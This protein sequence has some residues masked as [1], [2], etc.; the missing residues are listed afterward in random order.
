MTEKTRVVEVMDE[1]AA[2]RDNDGL[3][4]RR[5]IWEFRLKLDGKWKAFSTGTTNY[6]DARKF[7]QRKEKELSDARMPPEKAKWPL[8]KAADVWLASRAHDTAL[9]SQRRYRELVRAL[10]RHFPGRTLGDITAADIQGYQIRRLKKIAPRSLNLELRV[11]RMILKDAKLWSRLA[12]DY[13]PVREP[14]QGIGRVLTPEQE[15]MLFRVA[16][17]RPEW[18]VAYLCAILAA[19]TTCRGGEIKGLRLS[20]ID[21]FEKLLN[22]R[23]DA[24]KTD[25]GCRVIALNDAAVWAL[26]KLRARAEALGASQ[27]G[28]YLLPLALYR[29]TKTGA[30]CA[31]TGFDPSQPMHDFRSGW[32]SLTAAA[33]LK[34]LRFHD[35]RH[36]AITKLCEAGAP[37]STIM[38][39]AGH[40]SRAMLEHYS[41]IRIEAKRQAV[42]AICTP[43]PAEA[44]QATSANVQ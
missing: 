17:S 30:P 22:I 34:G 12:D 31:G 40:V 24:T 23:R 16:A 8:A 39:M 35:L 36:H 21:L 14:K 18:E 5:G 26:G 27:P 43:V 19:N 25:A 4:R 10:I 37:E 42:A 20:D 28:H 7:R 2:L 41:H 38:S 11:L 29:H 9:S 1:K 33:G 3:H 15:T 13:K 6:N 32:R 44:E